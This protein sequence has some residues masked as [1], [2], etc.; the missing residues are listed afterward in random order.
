VSVITDSLET[1]ID[2]V[3]L[4]PSV[5]L[6]NVELTPSAWR[7]LLRL[8]VCALQDITE[9]LTSGVRTSTSAYKGTLVALE[10]TA[11]MSLDPISVFVLQEESE[12]LFMLVNLLYLHRIEKESLRVPSV[13]L[14][15]EDLSAIEESVPRRT[16]VLMIPSALPTTVAPLSTRKLD[17]NALILVT[18]KSV[19]LPLTASLTIIEHHVTAMNLTQG[20]LTTLNPGVFLSYLNPWNVIRMNSVERET[21]AVLSKELIRASIPVRMSSVGPTRGAKSMEDVRNVF[22]MI[23]EW[24]EILLT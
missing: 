16:L 21:F 3:L 1:P 9:I 17:I 8:N 20:I 15:Q 22:V 7:E 12:T 18:L 24:M 23:P 19:V 2:L 4:F 11:S 6:S 14:A 13:K 5:T 10:Q